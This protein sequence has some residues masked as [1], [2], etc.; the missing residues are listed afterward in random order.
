VLGLLVTVALAVVLRYYRIGE[1]P[2]GLNSDEAVGGV[3]A[4]ETL[5]HG[6]QL[7]YSGQGG[8]S[9]LGFY[10]AAISFALFGPSV[11]ALRGTAAFA[12]LVGVVATYFAT[13]E[14]FRA[15]SRADEPI[16]GLSRAQF[17]ALLAT[18]GLAT[19]LWH[20]TSSRVAFAAVGV[21]FLQVPANYFLWRGL[22]T[23]RRIHFVLSGALLASVSYIYLSGGF[24]PLVYLVF[25][26]LQWL[27][28]ILR[29]AVRSRSRGRLPSAVP[30]DPPLLQQ[31]FWN[32][33]LCAAVA[34]VLF[35]PM[36]YFLLSAPDLATGRAQ[37]A[38]FTNPLI[39]KGDLWGTLWR[40]VWGNLAAFGLSTSWLTGAPPGNLIL[41]IPMALLFLAGFAI[42]LRRLRQPA[43]L[44][45]LIYW[46]IMLLPSILSPDI[47]PHQ[48]RAL[49]AA[50]AV[51][52]LVSVGVV[53]LLDAARWILH[54]M[55]GAI[56]DRQPSGYA[57]RAGS[58]SSVAVIVLAGIGLAQVWP[59]YVQFHYY[60]VEWPATNDAQDAFH[61]YA[62]DLAAEMSKETDRQAVFL[63][64]RDTAAGD[65]NPNYTVA[66]LYTGQADYAWVVDNE[67]TLEQTLNAAV[68]SNQLVHVVRWKTSKHTGADPKE[69]V[70]YYL[71]KHG[72]FVERR[73]FTYYDIETYRLD[74]PGPDLS[75]EALRPAHI[76]F[77]G[78]IVLTGYAFGDA[79]GEGEVASPSVSAGELLWVRLCFRLTAPADEDL[80]V[81]VAVS[82]QAGHRVGQIDKL[83]LNNFLHQASRRWEPGQEVDAYFLVP[84]VAA[85]APGDYRLSAAVY[86]AD[87]LAR[88]PTSQGD[89]AQVVTLGSV[90]VRPDLAPPD[91]DALGLDLALNQAV[92]EDLTLLGLSSTVGERVRPGQH[93]SLALVWR[94]DRAP[95]RDYRASLRATQ[96]EQSWPLTESMPL[97]GT[98][99][100]TT[101]WAAGQVVRGWLDGRVPR[102]MESGDYPLSVY[103]T[104]AAGEELA[105]LALGTLSVE[106]W[107]RRFEAPPL[108]R[109]KAAN[110]GDQVELLGYDLSVVT[111]GAGGLRVVL[112]WRARAEMDLG[113]VTFVHVL[114]ETGQ[115]VSQMDHV[116]GGGAFPTTGWLKGEVV[117]D[118]F[119]LRWPEG[120]SPAATQ[121]EVGLYDPRTGR[122]L[123]VQD[124]AP[125]EDRVLLPGPGD[126]VSP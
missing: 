75:D 38:F 33:A 40:S 55:F 58:F 12:G 91:P 59:L 106:G 86:G 87:S 23:G 116:P 60:F 47:V 98:Y 30:T 119:D 82:D 103:I 22:N 4:L 34:V 123:W 89:A 84:I 5:R 96:D 20:T 37:Q 99:Y 41:P 117:A 78:Q 67:D 44:F 50:P 9:S 19:S 28:V 122:R 101:Q 108:Q 43:Y 2:P 51:Y 111:E 107:P 74:G 66:F 120:L 10:I 95:A 114:D 29:S 7:Y 77:G 39:N 32:L 81:S 83:L 14:M 112:Y 121:L 18:L 36:L 1:V 79:S 46:A 13:R 63:L 26:L 52:V 53:G 113:Y 6:P 71:E 69:V 54:K 94:A 17:I 64:L 11:A 65:I 110:F 102:E 21:P 73:S 61:V 109:S 105:D 49:G 57:T 3:G 56:G 8:A 15:S 70:R 62:V 42:S 35:L 76:D 92:S 25:F 45:A 85:S 124:S 16:L 90:A 27:L 80:K 72:A 126:V 100:P 48:A 24:A 93:A 118:E 104:D 68:Q 115:V 125:A 88:L 31:H 97:A